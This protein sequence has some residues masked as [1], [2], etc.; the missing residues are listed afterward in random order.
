ML[1]LLNIH[2]IGQFQVGL[3]LL[4]VHVPRLNIV[5]DGL[6]DPPSNPQKSAAALR[7]RRS[8][9]NGVG[10]AQGDGRNHRTGG[11]A[12]GNAGKTEGKG[13][14]LGNRP[15]CLDLGLMHVVQQFNKLD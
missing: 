1:P 14:A 6:L 11:V 2:F 10:V 8:K 9:M 7:S 5:A 3:L 13:L 4:L 15:D 12:G